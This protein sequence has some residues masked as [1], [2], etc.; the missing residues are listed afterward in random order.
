MARTRTFLQLRQ[1]ALEAVDLEDEQ[2]VPVSGAEL[3]RQVNQSIADLHDLLIEHGGSSY[4][5]QVSTIATVAGA[6]TVSLPTAFYKLYGVDISVETGKFAPA[7]PMRFELRNNFDG[8][9]GWNAGRTVCYEVESGNPSLLR[10]WPT[11]AAV[12]SVRVW[13]VAHATELVAD[14]DA[15]DG[16]NGWEKWV[17]TDVG[18]WLRQKQEQDATDLERR[19]ARMT[20]RISKMAPRRDRGEPERT[21]DTRSRG[22]PNDGWEEDCP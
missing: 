13:Y 4:G 2:Y 7:E 21:L 18:I 8:I 20:E 16:I 22:F 10:F 14:G 9:A 17:V 11:P 3:Q 5:R 15:F 1:E 12:H 19:L 6:A